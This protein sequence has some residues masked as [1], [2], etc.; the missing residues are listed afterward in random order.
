M[1]CNQC[2][3]E[4]EAIAL[5]RAYPPLGF[6]LLFDE[7]GR[8]HSYRRLDGYWGRTEPQQIK[9]WHALVAAHRMQAVALAETV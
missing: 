1:K 8:Y 4:P 3:S 9:L 6:Y 2:V 5:A 7:E